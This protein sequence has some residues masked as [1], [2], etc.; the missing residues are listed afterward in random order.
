MSLFEHK[1]CRGHF[2]D[3]GLNINRILFV[4]GMVFAIM[5]S[6]V[7]AQSKSNDR[8]LEM[9]AKSEEIFVVGKPMPLTITV[10]NISDDLVLVPETCVELDYELTII[11]FGGKS[12]ALTEKGRRMNSDMGQSLC[13]RKNLKLQPGKWKQVVINASALYEMTRKGSYTITVT[14]SFRPIGGVMTK[15]QSTPVSVTIE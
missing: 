6:S 2:G 5:L 1:E 13:R 8:I 7:A 12:P 4:F 3:F 10:E 14:K 15:V 11:D 9:T